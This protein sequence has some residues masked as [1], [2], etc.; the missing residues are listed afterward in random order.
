MNATTNEHCT[1]E[2]LQGGWSN[3]TRN[4]I[5]GSVC[6]SSGKC[7]WQLSGK[8]TD[9]IIATNTQTKETWTVFTMPPEFYPNNHK[10]QYGM[11]NFAL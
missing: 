8:Y 1:L 11:N 2:F 5:T 9:K 10:K 4:A 7:I 3:K 6:D